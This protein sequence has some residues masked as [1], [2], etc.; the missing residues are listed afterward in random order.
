M[1]A[2]ITLLS[3]LRNPFKKRSKISIK[4]M[5]NWEDEPLNF[6]SIL[7]PNVEYFPFNKTLLYGFP[8]PNKTPL[9]V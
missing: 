4:L 7:S 2:V 5:N 8:T 1:A 3:V 6:L 9:T